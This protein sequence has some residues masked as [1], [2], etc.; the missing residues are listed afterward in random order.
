MGVMGPRLSPPGQKQACCC[1]WPCS[2]AFCT[3]LVPLLSWR[4]WFSSSWAARGVASA[5]LTQMPR[6]CAGSSSKTVTTSLTRY[7]VTPASGPHCPL[8]HWHCGGRRQCSVWN[9][10]ARMR[11]QHSFCKK[12]LKNVENNSLKPSM[13]QIES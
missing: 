4:S 6:S 9:R 7:A 5:K 1:T 3:M 13:L 10:P 11:C 2:P 8:C 12:H